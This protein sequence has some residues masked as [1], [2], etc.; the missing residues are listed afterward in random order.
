MS[1]CD[2]TVLHYGKVT[3]GLMEQVKGI[4]YSLGDF[5]G[6]GMSE[7]GQRDPITGQSVQ[8]K[9]IHFI[10]IYLAPGD[11]HHFHS[12][13]QWTGT[14]LR[15]FPG[16]HYIVWRCVCRQV[17]LCYVAVVQL[18]VHGMGVAALLYVGH[19][20]DYSSVKFCNLIGQTEVF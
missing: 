1:P 14:L 11:Y 7:S 3:N 19:T 2:G 8:S 4:T 17:C 15:H 5:L 16:T 6:P 18:C 20:L 10:T 13:A 12:P 9:C